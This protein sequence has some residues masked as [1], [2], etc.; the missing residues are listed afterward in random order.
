MAIPVTVVRPQRKSNILMQGR[1]VFCPL[2][3]LFLDSNFRC[4]FSSLGDFKLDRSNKDANV[5]GSSSMPSSPMPGRP[6]V[7]GHEQ[8]PPLEADQG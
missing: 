5:A 2:L 1:Q 8:E 6:E 4:F 3:G 7:L